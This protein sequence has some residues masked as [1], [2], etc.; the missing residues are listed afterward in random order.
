M[1]FIHGGAFVVGASRAGSLDGRRLS[2]RGPVVMVSF[3]YRLGAL[4]FLA[5][6][7]GLAGN[8]GFRDQQL[9][10]RWVRDNARAFQ[11]DA[12][13]R[14]GGRPMRSHGLARVPRNT[15]LTWTTSPTGFRN[16]W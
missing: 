9:A 2:A 14:G 11:G 1:V 7:E 5:G 6:V 12:V 8:Y 4:G 10:L 16:D 13:P 3:D 15:K